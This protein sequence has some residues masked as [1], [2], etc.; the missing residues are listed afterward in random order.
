MRGKKTSEAEII[1]IFVSYSRTGSY[2]ATAKEMKMPTNTVK[3]IIQRNIS[4]KKFAKLLD[5]NK[6]E[7]VDA[8]TEII[9]KATN[10]LKS[11]LDRAIDRETELDLLIEELYDTD[12]EELCDEK[13]R[14]L[15]D[16]LEKL[17]II[18][19]GELAR[20]MGVYYDK[21]SRAKG[22][23]TENVKIEI[24]LSD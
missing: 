8:A 2:S 20:V 16:K 17:K 15:I 21:R 1:E 24:G 23:I 18:S 10:L 9:D 4:N 7:F 19:C 11:K 12:E 14:L 22:E 6:K 13:K 3:G 5:E